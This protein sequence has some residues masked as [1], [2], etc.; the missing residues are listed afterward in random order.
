MGGEA[1]TEQVRVHPLLNAGTASSVLTGVTRCFA[2]DGLIAGVPAIARKE[3]DTGFFGQ[4][5]PVGAEFLEQN[6]TQHHASQLLVANTSGIEGH[7]NGSMKRCASCIDELR[8]FF[9]TEN[10]GQAVGLLGIRSVGNTPRFLK[11]LNV[12]KPQRT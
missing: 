9:L 8:H 4:T 1:V 12:E 7:E 11:R 10:G 3:Q 2:V 6:G 5:P